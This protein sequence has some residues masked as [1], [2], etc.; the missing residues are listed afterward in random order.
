MRPPRSRPDATEV[1]AAVRDAA[2]VA[3]ALVVL[4]GLATLGAC[5]RDVE[6]S[7][8]LPGWLLVLCGASLVLSAPLAPPRWAIWAARLCAMSALV[9]AGATMLAYVSVQGGPLPAGRFGGRASPQVATSALLAAVALLVLERRANGHAS[10]AQV[11]ALVA[12]SIPTVSL[13][14]FAFDI[15]ELYRAPRQPS[16]GLAILTATGILILSAGILAARPDVGPMALLTSRH[17]G[18]ITARRL[19]LG[20]LAFLPVAFLIVLGERIGFYDEGGV[21]ALLAFFALVEGVAVIFLTCARLDLD[22]RERGRA[23]ERLRASEAHAREM[24]EQAAE[25]IMIA[26]VDG[27]YTDVNGAACRLLCLP[28]ERIVG[29]LVQ[30]FVAPEELERL[31]RA[32]QA[33]RAGQTQVS[34]WTIQRGDGVRIAVELSMKILPDGRWLAFV[35]DITER[36]HNQTELERALEADHRRYTDEAARRAWLMSIIDQMPEGVILLNEH[37]GIEAMNRAVLS[38]SPTNANA[39][40]ADGL[41]AMF[42]VRKPDG[43]LLSSDEFPVV[44]ALTDGEITTDQELQV[45]F[46][47]GR[48]VPILASAAPVRDGAGRITGAVAVV[49]DITA[50]KE[51]DRL[52]EE[53]ASVIAHDLRQPVGAI[54]LTAE[55]LLGPRS[56][57]LSSQERRAIERIGSA[58]KR[59]A[60]M[61]E[62]LLDFSRIEAKR[63]SVRPRDVD[64]GAI[65]DAVVESQRGTNAIRLEGDPDLRVSVD[66]DRVHQVL[67]NLL[68]NAVKYGRPDAE[69]QIEW[70]DRGERLEVVVT[71]QGAGIPPE[72][73]PQLFSRFGRTRGARA[74]RTPGIGL[75]LYIARG[76]VEAHGGRIWA[77]SVPG[78]STSFH[79]T[80]PMTPHRDHLETGGLDAPAPGP[81]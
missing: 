7:T 35:R 80:L 11:L 15:P 31:S 73:M 66:P 45:R 6:V 78:E 59:L 12:G 79:F 16:N 39:V 2:P 70:L 9:L 36:R 43:G 3:G 52:R 63:L 76:L 56:D 69:I 46:K 28:R 48:L 27:R 23:E 42:E 40:D 38:L 67:D 49:R 62:D 55:S 77:E 61:I 4:I 65:I 72:E 64:F 22:D 57:G 68:S 54:S 75:G 60:R 25:G 19:L 26:D 58:S 29:R 5:W 13:L 18:G 51:L 47:D 24:F 30:S 21:S 74:H 53:W 34:E 32:R 71:N 33:L 50:L 10:Q 14:G 44:L 81:A 1:R 8:P 41:A 37:G 20:L 17:A